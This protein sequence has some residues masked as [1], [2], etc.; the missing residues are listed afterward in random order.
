[1]R[2]PRDLSVAQA[3]TLRKHLGYVKEIVRFP[4]NAALSIAFRPVMTAGA[5]GRSHRRSRHSRGPIALIQIIRDGWGR[6]TLL[7]WNR[8]NGRRRALPAGRHNGM[9]GE[10][11]GQQIRMIIVGEPLLRRDDFQRVFGIAKSHVF[12]PRRF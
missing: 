1:M 10:D 9:A 7:R 6:P 11:V 8:F 2:R 4:L 12:L 5:A 3:F